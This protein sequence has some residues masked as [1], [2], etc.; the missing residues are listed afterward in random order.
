MNVVHKKDFKKQK[1]EH[2]SKVDCVDRSGY[3]PLEVKYWEML[4]AGAN[5]ENIRT[6]DY[7]YDRNSI[8]KAIDDVGLD[9]AIESTSLR[10]PY[11]DKQTADSL[12]KQKF[13]KYKNVKSKLERIDELKKEYFKSLDNKAIEEATIN[14]I[15]SGEIK[16][17]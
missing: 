16:I 4:Y 12:L 10:S 9:K 15:K 17:D 3:V 1:S 8:L 14:K 2:I 5:L 13:S 6:L 7:G 11:I